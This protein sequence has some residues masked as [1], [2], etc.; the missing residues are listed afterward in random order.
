MSDWLN[1]A[2]TTGQDLHS[3]WLSRRT[4]GPDRVFSSR[5]TYSTEHVRTMYVLSSVYVI[6]ATWLGA[7]TMDL[8]YVHVPCCIILF[9]HIPC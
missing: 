8:S 4:D 2:S 3:T 6:V 9:V 7:G 1:G 5:S